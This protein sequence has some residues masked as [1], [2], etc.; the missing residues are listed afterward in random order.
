MDETSVRRNRGLVE[1]R[2]SLSF[3]EFFF[4]IHSVS[5][6]DSSLARKSRVVVFSMMWKSLRSSKSVA[7]Q[8]RLW[9]TRRWAKPCGHSII[10]L[11]NPYPFILAPG[12]L[13]SSKSKQSITIARRHSLFIEFEDP[14][15]NKQCSQLL[16]QDFNHHAN[17]TIVIITS[18]FVFYLFLLRYKRRRQRTETKVWGNNNQDNTE[19]STIVSQQPGHPTVLNLWFCKAIPSKGKFCRIKADSNPEQVMES[20]SIS[21]RARIVAGRQNPRFLFLNRWWRNSRQ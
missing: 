18:M 11:S 3:V 20:P 16:S 6:V 19:G 2:S 7:D 4:R 8:H 14:N 5:I 10:L 9:I 17:S 12:V 13:R 15:N 21:A 1:D